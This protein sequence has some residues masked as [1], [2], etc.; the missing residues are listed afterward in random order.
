LGVLAMVVAGGVASA[1]P[2]FIM[3]DGEAAA[4]RRATVMGALGEATA[5]AGWSGATVKLTQAESAALLQCSNTATPWSCIPEAFGAAGVH[6]VLV[7]TVDQKPGEGGEPI[8]VLSGKLVTTDPDAFTVRQRF[9]E[10]CS[11]ERL[12]TEASQLATQMLRDVAVRQGRTAIV[13]RSEP[14]GAQVSLDGEQIGVTNNTY[15]T[16]PGKHVISMEKPG[17]ATETREID[18]D[19]GTSREV[20]VTLHA[21]TAPTVPP[22]EPRPSRV[23]PAIV[24]GAGVTALVAGIVLQATADGPPLGEE[25]PSRI[26]SAPGIGL[27]VAGGVVTGVGVYLWMRASG[28]HAAGATPTVSLTEHGGMVGWSQSY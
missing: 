1:A 25:Q 24:I 15:K 28:P 23:V 12:T 19:E 20:D 26:Y 10:H 16:Y 18:V 7:V 6:R 14:P 9:C 17:Y 3:V 21:S 27:A 13:L 5:G 2:G 4:D 22:A 11:E 8:I